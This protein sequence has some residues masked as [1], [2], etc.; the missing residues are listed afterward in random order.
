V[1]TLGGVDI[2]WFDVNCSPSFQA[3][4]GLFERGGQGVAAGLFGNSYLKIRNSEFSD[5]FSYKLILV[6]ILLLCI[7]YTCLV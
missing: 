4:A 6:H 7:L 3:A 1:L 2:H 5:S